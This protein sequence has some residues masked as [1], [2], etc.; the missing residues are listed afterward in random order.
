MIQINVK[1]DHKGNIDA[2][3]KKLKN[4]FSS[5]KTADILRD[6]KCFTKKSV[7]KRLQKKKAVYIQQLKSLND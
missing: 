6:K 4:K 5:Q 7:K 1:K 3:L 2:A